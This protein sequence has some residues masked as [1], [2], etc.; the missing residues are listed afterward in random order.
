MGCNIRKERVKNS[1]YNYKIVLRL[2]FASIDISTEV[3]AVYF[4]CTFTENG[5]K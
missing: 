3:L 1:N 2:F 4:L 5:E